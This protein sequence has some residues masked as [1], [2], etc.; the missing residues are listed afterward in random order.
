M[1]SRLVGESDATGTSKVVHPLPLLSC[2]VPQLYLD[3][4][5]P[6][7]PGPTTRDWLE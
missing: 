3:A 6:Q 4:L 5:L 1:G 2:S 7:Y